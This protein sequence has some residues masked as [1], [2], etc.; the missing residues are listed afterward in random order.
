M[1]NYSQM[2]MKSCLLRFMGVGSEVY[3]PIVLGRKGMGAELKESYFRQAVKNVEAGA[4]GYRFDKQNGELALGRSGSG[5]TTRE[6]TP[7]RLETNG[8]ELAGWHDIPDHGAGACP[9]SSLVHGLRRNDSAGCGG[10]WMTDERQ[11]RMN[12]IA[13]RVAS[14]MSI[15]AAGAQ[16]GLTKGQSIRAWNNVK[17]RLG[18]QAV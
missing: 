3:S 18:A 6:G 16:I 8:A 13:A 10:V 14:G 5:M 12:H 15:E 17:K 11:H 2:P 9:H 1:F 7:A 4:K